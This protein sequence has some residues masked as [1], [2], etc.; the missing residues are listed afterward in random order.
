M[1]TSDSRGHLYGSASPRAIRVSVVILLFTF[2]YAA[3]VLA[4]GVVPLNM[5]F[6]KLLGAGIMPG[7][8][9]NSLLRLGE[10]TIVAGFACWLGLAI[11]GRI[12]GRLT[13]RGMLAVGAAMSGA[14]AGAVDV[15]MQK[16]LVSYLV[17]AARA[18]LAW[19]VV[20]SC[21]VTAVVAIAITLLF[22]TRSTKPLQLED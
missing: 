20:F 6:R 13:G 15:G 21:V 7:I 18:G 22:I 5:L 2:A 8:W 11:S 12:R 19:G 14:L 1:A 9:R 16:L 10:R 4:I 17:K 3:A